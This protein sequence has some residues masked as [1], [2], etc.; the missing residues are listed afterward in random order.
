MV[1]LDLD[2]IRAYEMGEEE[3]ESDQLNRRKNRSRR[4]WGKQSNA[5]LFK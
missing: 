4:S 2:I 1:Y 5:A 3:W